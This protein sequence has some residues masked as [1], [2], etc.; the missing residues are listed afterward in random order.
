M[1]KLTAFKKE[2]SQSYRQCHTASFPSDF[3]VE[4]F[5]KIEDLAKELGEIYHI[6]KNLKHQETG[7]DI[8]IEYN[9]EELISFDYSNSSYN[10]KCNIFEDMEESIESTFCEETKEIIALLKIETE[11]MFNKLKN[12]KEINDLEEEIK[13]TKQ[14]IKS[15]KIDM[16]IAKESIEESKSELIKLKVTRRNK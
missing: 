11:K 2:S 15:A 6:Q 13:K 8:E 3:R 7:Y 16:E 9:N 1:F 12:I 14:D 10:D 5:E 4:K